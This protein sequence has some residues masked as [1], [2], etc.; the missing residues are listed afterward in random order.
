M[1]TLPVNVVYNEI[2]ARL[3]PCDKLAFALTCKPYYDTIMA[4]EPNFKDVYGQKHK[5]G[6]CLYDMVNFVR[7]GGINMAYWAFSYSWY[8]NIHSPNA[9][10]LVLKRTDKNQSIHIHGKHSHVSIAKLMTYFDEHIW[11]QW[12]H[13]EMHMGCW[14]KSKQKK[15]EFLEITSRM[16]SKQ[17]LR[18]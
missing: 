17:L 13:I 6:Q 10:C 8:H 12:D 16:P 9:P 7:T 4:N 14:Y 2:C 1:Q 11:P 3:A 15:K 18:I 5:V